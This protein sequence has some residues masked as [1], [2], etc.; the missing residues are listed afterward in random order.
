[1]QE[2]FSEAQ[3]QALIAVLEVTGA[4][5]RADAAN[6]A[7]VEYFRKYRQDWSEALAELVELGLISRRDD[8]YALTERGRTQAGRLREARPPIYYWYRAYYE[9]TRTSAAY[10]QFCERVF[11]R[12]FSQHG[13]SD[14]A[15]IDVML[16]RLALRPGDRVLELGCG[17]G[18]MAEY[19]AHETGAHVTGIDYIPEAIAQAQERAAGQP[20]QLAFYVGDIGHLIDAQS[21]LTLCPHSFDALIAVDTLY[22][23]DLYNTL[24]QMRALLAP[25]G[26]MA[27]L[28]GQDKWL[29]QSEKGFDPST[30][31]PL[32]TPLGQALLSLGLDFETVDFSRANYQHAQLKK[33]VLEELRPD[34][35]AEG[36]QFILKNR[37]AEA[38][39]VIRA[40]EAGTAVRYLYHVRSDA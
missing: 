16:D 19:I 22:F 1:M 2:P 4:E 39:G 23:T 24:R 36:N 28:Y 27:L 15:Q 18:A 33:A 31:S 20:D 8:A 6:L 35:E 13:F 30:L 3:T 17:N 37:Y 11:G 38:R 12:N 21:T 10:A 14:M 29:D 32:K 7:G 5:R 25:G 9:A 40:F 26:Q 34:L